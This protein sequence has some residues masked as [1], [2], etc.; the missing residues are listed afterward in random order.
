[1]LAHIKNL[2]NK[3]K[4]DLIIKTNQDFEKFF[5]KGSGYHSVET[6]ISA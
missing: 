1:M 2:K 3:L 6:W 4:M 5:Q